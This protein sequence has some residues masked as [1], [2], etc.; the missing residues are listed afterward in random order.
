MYGQRDAGGLLK[1]QRVEVHPGSWL[2][3]ARW[4]P[5]EVSSLQGGYGAS[6]RPYGGCTAHAH[7]KIRV[8]NY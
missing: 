4:P 3:V 2:V 7:N 8:M 5:S 6:C 1:C